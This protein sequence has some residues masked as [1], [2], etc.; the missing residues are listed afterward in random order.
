LWLAEEMPPWDNRAWHGNVVD[1]GEKV[2]ERA[3]RRKPAVNREWRET[4]RETAVDVIIHIVKTN[5]RGMFFC[6]RKE[7]RQV[8]D[9][10]LPD[11]RVRVLASEPVTE[12]GEFGVHGSL[13]YERRLP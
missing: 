4:I 12:L 11:A 10:V 13:L 8:T 6:I 1:H 2:I 5:R 3:Q 9:V 7:E